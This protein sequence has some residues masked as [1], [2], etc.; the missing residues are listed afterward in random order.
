MFQPHGIRGFASDQIYEYDQDCILEENEKTSESKKAMLVTGV[1]GYFTPS[2]NFIRN[3]FLRATTAAPTLSMVNQRALLSLPTKYGSWLK[4][5]SDDINPE[6]LIV[7]NQSHPSPP[8]TP[9][10][11]KVNDAISHTVY[12][13]IGAKVTS[14]LF[15]SF[16]DLSVEEQIIE[17]DKKIEQVKKEGINMN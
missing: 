3:Y 15:R 4:L 17:L 9:F 14:D 11:T 8:E 1:L 2:S 16:P 7:Q 10:F 5:L 6:I 12:D 13:I